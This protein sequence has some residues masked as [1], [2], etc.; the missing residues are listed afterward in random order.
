MAQPVVNRC[1]SYVAMFL[2][3]LRSRDRKNSQR[4][5]DR[6]L[7]SPE[8]YIALTRL[9]PRGCTLVLFMSTVEH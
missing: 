7:P 3:R 9:A 4:V 2:K 8:G 1:V 6:A 5:V